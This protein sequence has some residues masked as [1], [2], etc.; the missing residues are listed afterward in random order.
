MLALMIFAAISVD[1]PVARPTPQQLKWADMEIGMFIHFAPNTWQDREGDDLSTPLSQINPKKLNTDQWARA[2]KN[3]G[4]KYVVLVTKHVGGFCL[5]Q[6]DTTDYGIK[7]TPWKNGK[8]DVVADLAASCRKYGLALGFYVSPMSIHDGA[9]VGGVIDDPEKQ[10]AYAERYRKQLEELLTRYGPVFEIWFDGNTH[11][12][13]GD[14]LDKLAPK[15]ICFQGPRASIR[16]VGNE[17]GVAPYPTWNSVHGAKAASG[18]SVGRDGDPTGDHWLPAEVDVSIRR[19]YWFWSTKNESSLL[20]LD[21]LVEVYY[22][23]VGH[24]ANL[25]LNVPPNS[26]GLIPDADFARLKEFGDEIR[27]RFG[28]PLALAKG[29]DIHFAQPTVVDH[30]VMMEDIRYGERVLRYRVEALEDGVWKTVGEGTEIGHK[31][32]QPISEGAYD[33]L[34]LVVEESQGEVKMRRFAAYR[35]GVAA[36]AR[37]PVPRRL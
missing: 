13:V 2:A 1:G 20:S 5:W 26:D 32:I 6:T 7:N 11:L 35:V 37:T 34:R 8:G 24:G 36:P 25:L 23:S 17:E 21:Q 27:R 15:A 10:Q 33:E 19:P 3:L 18:E 29:E 9:R 28:K 31:R 14:V 16:W 30:V 12:P 22:R 4:A